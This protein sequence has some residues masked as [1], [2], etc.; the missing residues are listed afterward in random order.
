G[1]ERAGG[2]VHVG[3]G[4]QLEDVGRDES[5]TRAAPTC[6]APA[7]CQRVERGIA[8][9]KGSNAADPVVA[10]QRF[11]P[12]QPVGTERSPGPRDAVDARVE[13]WLQAEEK[14]QAIRRAAA[15]ERGGRKEA[16]QERRHGRVP[17]P[18]EARSHAGPLANGPVARPEKFPASLPSPFLRGP[19]AAQTKSLV[20]CQASAARNDRIS[21]RASGPA[22]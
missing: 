18:P 19:H 22:T 9:A 5:I 6:G 10:G 11:E 7:G 21:P 15:C 4:G 16:Y 8:T 2:G 1:G 12:G 3:A 17:A 14:L 20:S 13:P